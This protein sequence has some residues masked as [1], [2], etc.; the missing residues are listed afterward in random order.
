MCE[1]FGPVMAT[2]LLTWEL[3]GG[4]GHFVN[5]RALAG[6]LVAEGHR[7]FA[8]LR[9]VTHPKTVLGTDEVTYLQ[10]PFRTSPPVK[11]FNPAPTFAHILY[12]NGFND[13]AA[14][15]GL[16]EA[17]R[18]LFDYVNPDLVVL[19]HSPTALVA[20]RGHGSRRALIGTG[21]FCPPLCYPL[22]PLVKAA[23]EFLRRFEDDENVILQR[24]NRIIATRAGLPVAN[25]GALYADV[26]ENFLTT[27]AELDNYRSHRADATYWGPV[28]PLGIGKSPEWPNAPGPRIFAYFNKPFP[29]LDELLRG[30]A[31]HGMPTIVHLSGLPPDMERRHRC[32][33]LRFEREPL[34]MRKVGESCDLAIFNG[35]HGSTAAIL[36]AGKPILQIPI[37]LEQRHN[38]EA[39]IRLG[40]GVRAAPNDAAEI[41]EKIDT[42]IA[43]HSFAAAAREFAAKYSRFA[44]A[45]QAC[46]IV[47]RTHELAIDL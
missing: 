38:A 46:R 4:M 25:L 17:W 43:S 1:P 14:L 20:L 8:A 34:D 45:E 24:V 33:T 47:K 18:Q 41:L 32:A 16:C 12:N 31:T 9:D 23:P 6:G 13:D 30:L 29:A 22:P 5:L 35:N 40:A 42:S 37:H 2:I 15:A 26:D 27:F 10:A 7:V 36:L 21:F 39:I 19:D 11:P 28:L 3:G 44:P